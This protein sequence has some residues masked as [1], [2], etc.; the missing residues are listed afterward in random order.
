MLYG[1]QV[2]PEETSAHYTL[3]TEG[4]VYS[5]AGY[6]LL[7]ETTDCLAQNVTECKKPDNWVYPYT[8]HGLDRIMQKY[9]EVGATVPDF[10]YLVS[11][12]RR[13]PVHHIPMQSLLSVQL[14][15]HEAPGSH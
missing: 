9:F 11:F 10:Q 4:V 12:M 7:Y 15:C 6:K 13:G 8:N 1:G 14:R 5:G 3:V 2:V